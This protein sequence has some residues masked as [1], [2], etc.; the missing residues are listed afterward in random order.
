MSESDPAPQ[1]PIED[2]IEAS[3]SDLRTKNSAYKTAIG[4]S[5]GRADEVAKARARLAETEASESGARQGEEEC[6]RQLVDAIDAQSALLSKA[7]SLLVPPA[8]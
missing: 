2:Q 1:N 8:G 5:R 3:H 7:R 4:Q 6:K